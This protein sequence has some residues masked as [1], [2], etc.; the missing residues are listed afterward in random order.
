MKLTSSA[1]LPSLGSEVYGRRLMLI[2]AFVFYV[3]FQV[4]SALAPNTA[5]VLIFRLLGGSESSRPLFGTRF[6]ELILV[7]L[8]NAVSASCPLVVTGGILGDIF[9][10]EIRGMAISIFVRPSDASFSLPSLS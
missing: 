10:A 6:V 4:G 3:C 7:S 1:S 8:D 9:P 5:A 2:I